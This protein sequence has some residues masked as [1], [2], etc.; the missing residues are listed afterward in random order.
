MLVVH[1]LKMKNLYSRTKDITTKPGYIESCGYIAQTKSPLINQ[2][3]D[4]A[5][6]FSKG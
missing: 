5:L 6:N 1:K 3:H 4:I 2:W